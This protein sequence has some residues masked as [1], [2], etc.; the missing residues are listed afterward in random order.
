MIVS[1]LLM[2]K[3]LKCNITLLFW[4]QYHRSTTS[5]FYLPKNFIR[6]KSYQPCWGP[7]PPQLDISWRSATTLPGHQPQTK[8]SQLWGRPGPR[9]PW[10]RSD[11]H[12]LM[13]AC[14]E[15]AQP[16]AAHTDWPALCQARCSALWKYL[17]QC[18]KTK[19][20]T[21]RHVHT[22]T[23]LHARAHTHTHESWQRALDRDIL[24]LTWQRR[25]LATGD[26]Q[27]DLL[28]PGKLSKY[29]VKCMW[30]FL[31][32]RKGRWS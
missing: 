28:Q 12:S 10:E 27:A 3:H 22:R 24:T 2:K 5:V 31:N 8:T 18:S 23:C 32:L 16:T 21:C 19:L 25:I 26:H 14:A 11:P 20:Y 4:T 17:G 1:I 9:A 13:P 30:I 7:T 15:D 29:W 6:E